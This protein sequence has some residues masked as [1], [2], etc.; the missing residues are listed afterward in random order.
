MRDYIRRKRIYLHN[1]PGHLPFERTF[2]PDLP[3][4]LSKDVLAK[5]Y[6]EWVEKFDIVRLRHSL[7]KVELK[8]DPERM[9]VDIFRI[10]LLERQQAYLDVERM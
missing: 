3:Q 5:G 8:Q 4:Y 7:E 2:G 1:K 10:G 9:V 6:K